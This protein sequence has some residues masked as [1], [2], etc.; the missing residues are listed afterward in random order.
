MKNKEMVIDINKLIRK[1]NYFDGIQSL[2]LK[3]KM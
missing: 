2:T 3:K 1:N